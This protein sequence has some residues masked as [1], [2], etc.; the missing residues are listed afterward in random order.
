MSK[1]R[2]MFR[3][4]VLGI[5]LVTSLAALIDMSKLYWL[6]FISSAMT[7]VLI[8]ESI[9]ANY[10]SWKNRALA[11]AGEAVVVAITYAVVAFVNRRY[12]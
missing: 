11:L 6:L 3:F 12:F 10:T 7:L 1:S 5:M 2:E 9:F 8:T 4:V